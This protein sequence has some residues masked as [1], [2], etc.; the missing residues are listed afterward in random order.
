MSRRF[1]GNPLTAGSCHDIAPA[2]SVTQLLRFSEIRADW[3]VTNSTVPRAVLRSLDGIVTHEFVGFPRQWL[4]FF[5]WFGL[6]WRGSIAP[7]SYMPFFSDLNEEAVRSVMEHSRQRGMLRTLLESATACDS[8]LADCLYIVDH[9]RQIDRDAVDHDVTA[10]RHGLVDHRKSLLLTGWQS[11]GRPS[12]R[13]LEQAVLKIVPRHRD[14]AILPCA[15]RRPYDR[16][17]THKKIIRLLT[18]KGLAVHEV[19]KVVMTAIGLLPEEV[20]NEP[21]VVAYSAGV[22]DVY[23]L[24]R[25]ARS[26]F[27]DRSYETVFDCLQFEPYSDVLRIVHREGLIRNLTRVSIPGRRPFYIRPHAKGDTAL[28]PAPCFTGVAR[29]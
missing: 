28:A 21:S 26:F 13:A 2:M 19:D 15:L 16:S 20:W 27:S 7:P 14:A 18:A 10:I 4:P 29:P 3:F 8:V 22:P 11:Y 6:P 23:R 12:V 1:S 24:L 5:E 9:R 17:V 25:L